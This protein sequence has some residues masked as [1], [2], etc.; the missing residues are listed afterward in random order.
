MK[1]LLFDIGASRTRLAISEDGVTLGEPVIFNTPQSFEE[2][3]NAISEKAKQFGGGFGIAA[4]GI[5]GPINRDKTIINKAP[6]LP[7]WCDKPLKE[8]LS[9]V[10]ETEVY[11][12]NDTALVGLGEAVAGAGK[13]NSVV[14]YVTVSTGINGVKI[15]DNKIDKNYLGYEIGKQIIDFDESTIKGNWEDAISGAN[16]ENK[17]SKNPDEIEDEEIWNEEVNLLSYGLYNVILFWSPEILILG[18]GLM[19]KI[20]TQKVEGKIKE[21][22]TVFPVLP[23]IKKSE[24]GDVGGLYGALHFVKSLQ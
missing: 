14:A 11:L 4:G 10:L 6:N 17:Y 13:S 24:L 8:S 19:K 23:E 12:E 1:Y 5:A 15:V 2:G 3:I 7:N 16:L 22:F 20:D 21:I 9:E 18:G